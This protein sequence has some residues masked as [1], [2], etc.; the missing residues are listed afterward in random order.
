MVKTRKKAER[1]ILR[2]A[3]K[4]HGGKA[5]LKNW[6]IENFPKDAKDMVYVE[7]YSGAASVLF[8]KEPGPEEVLNDLHPGIIEIFKAIRDQPVEFLKKL[9]KLKYNE[10]TFEKALKRAE[11]EEGF[12]VKL[13]MAVNEYTLR[14]MSRGGMKK[15]FA[16]SDRLR[17]GQPGDVNAWET[18][19]DQI[20]LLSD[21]LQN[22]YVF[23]KPAIEVIRAFNKSNTLLYVD[24]P[25]L[26]STRASKTVYE[27]FEMSED[28]HKKLLDALC[29]FRGKVIVSGYD[30]ELYNEFFAKWTKVERT[31]V[32]HSSQ[33]KTKEYKV[34]ILWKNF[35]E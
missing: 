25:Y 4:C 22:V 18:A 14:R 7:P 2:P 5:Y 16:W 11:S 32:N 6:I 10:K 20:P 1:H 24:P 33:S 30:S 28:D 29:C 8:N 13:D 9:K 19:L 35:T 21:R 27:K 12:P 3:F 15:A 34:E 17:G 23:N 31:I 26:H